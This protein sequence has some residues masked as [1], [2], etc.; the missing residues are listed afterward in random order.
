VGVVGIVFSGFIGPTVTAWFTGRREWTKDWRA[1]AAA[2]QNDLR[3]VLDEAAKVLS[4]AVGRLR[5][6]LAAS[7]AGEELPKEPADFLGTLAPLGHRLRLRLPDSDPVVTA[8]DNAVEKLRAVGPAIASQAAFDAA[9]AEFDAARD[10]FLANSRAK[11]RAEIF[12][13]RGKKN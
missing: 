4:G 3:E 10:A 2:R 9:V 11:L 13:K 6:L 7:L 1:L 12:E 8:Y 5:P